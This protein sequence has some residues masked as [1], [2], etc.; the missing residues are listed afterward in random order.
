MKNLTKKQK[1][2]KINKLLD[3]NFIEIQ[4]KYINQ[5]KEIF[6]ENFSQIK[7]GNTIKSKKFI[8]YI[9]SSLESVNK[10]KPEGFDDNKTS[11]EHI[12]PKNPT[13]WNKLT[14]TEIRPYLNNIGNILLVSNKANS[15]MQN[16]RLDKKIE[17]LGTENFSQTIHFVKMHKNKEWD[18]SQIEKKNFE[19][20]NLRAR[21]LSDLAYKLWM[22]K[23]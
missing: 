2:K 14:K 7:L 18:F 4:K 9:L 3:T 23:L 13:K 10:L 8:R 22:Q 5:D 12:L 16:N 17:I 6:K 11:L 21:H 19:P 15:K 20:I 1:N